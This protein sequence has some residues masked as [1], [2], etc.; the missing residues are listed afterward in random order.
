MAKVKQYVNLPRDGRFVERNIE[1]VDRLGP[2]FYKATLA[3]PAPMLVSFRVVKISESSPYTATEK[4]RNRRFELQEPLGLDV[5]ASTVLEPWCKATL[6]PSGGAIYKIE[7]R[8]D[9]KTVA[10]TDEIETW[11]RLFFQ[12][13]HM[14]NVEVPALGP[15][16]DYFKTLYIELL[17]QPAGAVV[18][19]PHLEN[20]G[21]ADL[22]HLVTPKYTVDDREPWVLALVFADQLPQLAQI[23]IGV[24]PYAGEVELPS[25]WSGNETLKFELPEEKYLWFGLNPVDDAA[26]GG[27]GSW[28]RGDGVLTVDGQDVVIPADSISIDTSKSIR[29]GKAFNGLRIQ[30]PEGARNQNRFFDKSAKLTLDLWVL[31]GFSGGFALRDQN[32]LAV[33]RK[34]WWNDKQKADPKKLQVLNHEFGHKLGMVPKG[35]RGFGGPFELDAPE[36]LYGDVDL[37]YAGANPSKELEEQM[38]TLNN[39]KGHRGAHCGRDAKAKKKGASWNW[40]GTPGCTMFGATSTEDAHAPQNFCAVCAKLL[41]RQNL[42]PSD[43]AGLPGFRSLVK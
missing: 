2:V 5:N 20:A 17:D 31:N 36:S 35:G 40:S 30:L 4:K 43:A 41:I 27:K 29:G 15:M 14:T 42:N 9:D 13:F 16:F 34:A 12:I 19:I 38:K 8:A 11:R 24:A 32:L 6:P 26:N 7:A 33:A 25:Q 21:A 23:K 28:L 1:S 3:K 10:T 22:I 39:A 18:E 37:L